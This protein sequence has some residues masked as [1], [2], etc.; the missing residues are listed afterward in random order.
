MS[1]CVM[2]SAEL[3]RESHNS[4]ILTGKILE[5]NT[6]GVVAAIVGCGGKSTYFKTEI[7]LFY[8]IQNKTVV[9][10]FPGAL[11]ISLAL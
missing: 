8:F 9:Y 10:T 11:C 3:Q 6:N 5:L 2:I 1:L 4:L 7:Y